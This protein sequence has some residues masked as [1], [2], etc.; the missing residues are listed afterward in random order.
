LD[1]FDIVGACLSLICTFLFVRG[2]IFAWHLSA[3]AIPFDAFVYFRSQLFGDMML[4][5]LYFISAFYGWFQWRFGGGKGEVLEVTS[6]SIAEWQKLIVLLILA[7]AIILP[8]LKPFNRGDIATIDALTTVL[9]LGGQWLLCR[10]K[11]ETWLFWFVVDG[12][13]IYLY[14]VKSLPFHSIMAAIYLTMAIAGW[15]R[16]K[17]E[18]PSEALLKTG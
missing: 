3:I 12:L 6:L 4:Q 7:V 14:A 11:I 8:L 2:S 16:W 15:R 5:L 18:L 17:V 9:S 13:Y 10:K 1:G